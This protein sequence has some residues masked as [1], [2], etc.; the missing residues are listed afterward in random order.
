MIRKGVAL[1][2]FV[3]LLNKYFR[4]IQNLITRKKYLF[5]IY[6][7]NIL[8]FAIQILQTTSQGKRNIYF[9]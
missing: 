7:T 6:S 5:Y 4:K 3:K 1:K 9:M 8:S 2:Y